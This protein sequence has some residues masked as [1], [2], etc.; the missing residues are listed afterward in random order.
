MIASNI[1]AARDLGKEVGRYSASF[2][3]TWGALI[4]SFVFLALAPVIAIGLPLFW[5]GL[6]AGMAEV[7][8]TT[9]FLR[10]LPLFLGFV[11]LFAMGLRLFNAW[12]EW[13]TAVTVYELGFEY[14][15]RQ[16]TRR[17]CWDDLVNF[18]QHV[19]RHYYYGFIPVGTTYSFTLS[20][21]SGGMLILDERIGRHKELGEQMMLQMANQQLPQRMEEL[22]AGKLLEFGDLAVDQSGIRYGDKALPWNEV[23]EVKVQD[24]RVT[25][26]KQGKMLNKWASLSGED[27]RNAYVVLKISQQLLPKQ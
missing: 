7:L 2:G 16:G 5:S 27:V 25:V 12:R 4:M 14:C 17:L 3:H 21:R 11:L 6:G 13:A 24:G 9:P 10:Y 15:D 26:F 18:T 19:T 8:A 23:K 22:K 20:D 1:P